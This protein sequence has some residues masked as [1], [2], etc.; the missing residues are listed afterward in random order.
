MRTYSFATL[1]TAKA[2]RP[3]ATHLPFTIV[4][5]EGKLTLSSH[6]ARANVQWK[7]MEQ[8]EAL[9]IFTE[10]HAYISPGLYDKKESV[11]TWNYISVHAYG[12]VRIVHDQKE[13]FDLLESMIDT[14]E[15]DYRNQWNE[16][17]STYKTNMAKGIV[18]FQVDVTELQAAEKLSQNKT[19]EER[20]RIKENLSKSPNSMDQLLSGYIK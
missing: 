15:A 18:A 20:Q 16:L 14:F 9:V 7:K 12:K 2:N 19:D 3:I 4:E 10:P 17:S 1:V 11:P 8:L 5:K 6:L 13:V